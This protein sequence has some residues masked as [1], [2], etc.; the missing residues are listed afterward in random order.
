MKKRNTQPLR[1][2]D[3]T[4]SHD[5]AAELNAYQRARARFARADRQLCDL[6]EEFASLHKLLQLRNVSSEPEP[7]L[8]PAQAEL[9]AILQEWR[10]SRDLAR[11]LWSALSKAARVKYYETP[12]GE[13]TVH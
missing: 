6:S 10:Q 1:H 7:I 9:D 5:V 12:I 3:Q 11:R 4:G 8:V 2:H 13:G